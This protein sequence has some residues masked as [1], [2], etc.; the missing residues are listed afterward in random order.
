MRW[1]VVLGSLFAVACGSSVDSGSKLN[2][3]DAEDKIQK[4]LN[5]AGIPATSVV[6]PSNRDAKAGVEFDCEAT[7]ANDRKVT[8]HV[9]VTDDHGS[10]TF[11][12]STIYAPNVEAALD[13]SNNGLSEAQ[14]PD[15]V[16]LSGGDGSLDCTATF[17]AQTI[18]VTVT[19]T[20][21]SVTD[22]ERKTDT[23]T[24]PPDPRCADEWTGGADP[25]CDTC[26]ASH[27]CD[28]VAACASSGTP[29]A[30]YVLCVT[31]ACPG[32][33]PSCAEAQCGDMAEG[34]AAFEALSQ[35]MTAC[36]GC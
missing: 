4:A 2:A 31:D 18:T 20:D 15:G 22:V 1:I 29:C 24:N 7:D 3:G 25:A 30:K 21:G 8:V 33:D 9:T 5:D 11:E 36:P 23:P 26:A 13:G 17:D 28:G 16:T 19:I 27:C 10:V 34:K 14:C 35:C 32:G 12:T 6:C